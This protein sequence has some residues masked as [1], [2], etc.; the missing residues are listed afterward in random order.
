MVF[1]FIMIVR[2]LT[3]GERLLFS[4]FPDINF[5]FGLKLEYL[6]F[7]LATPVFSMF[8]NS[9]YPEEF[10]SKPLKIILFSSSIFILLV[11]FS[12]LIFF[13]LLNDY[14]INYFLH[15]LSKIKIVD[16]SH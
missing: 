14:H 6:S 4:Y 3:T 7:F 12:S 16:T 8:L 2:T 10:K 1:C 9:L 5:E 15:L 11:F 13:F